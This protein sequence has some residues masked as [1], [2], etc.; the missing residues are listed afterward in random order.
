MTQTPA[1]RYVTRPDAP[2]INTPEYDRWTKESAVSFKGGSLSATY[3]N[4]IQTLN[5]AGIG[6]NCN[7]PTKNVSVPAATVTYTIGGPS[8]TRKSFSYSKKQFNK[9]NSSMSAGG[10]PVRI[11]TGVGEYTGRLTGNL[12][13]FAAFLCEN[14]AF[15][16]DSVYFFSERGAQYGPFNPTFT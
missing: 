16:Y 4:L 7:P 12:E 14:S 3:G 9:K 5:V 10:Q 2:S 6:F 8:A 1:P 13:D 15:I 11:V